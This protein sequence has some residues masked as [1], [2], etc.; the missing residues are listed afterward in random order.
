MKTCF[1]ALCQ[2]FFTKEILA[3]YPINEN[4]LYPYGVGGSGTTYGSTLT[5]YDCGSVDP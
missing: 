1:F 2:I 4:N 3:V 5:Q